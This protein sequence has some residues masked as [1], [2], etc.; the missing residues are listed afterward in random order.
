[1]GH[2]DS[3]FILANILNCSTLT[4][5]Q[6]SVHLQKTASAMSKEIESIRKK[7]DTSKRGIAQW[8]Q[9]HLCVCEII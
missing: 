5:F 1:M 2:F 6:F 8:L 4:K 3:H 7:L 9:D